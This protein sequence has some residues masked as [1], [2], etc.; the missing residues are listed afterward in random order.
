MFVGD[1][2]ARH[3]QLRGPVRSDRNGTRLLWLYNS[4]VYVQLIG[5]DEQHMCR[6]EFLAG[7]LVLICML[8]LR[9]SRVTDGLL[10]DHF[11]LLS[12]IR[13]PNNALSLRNFQRLRMNIPRQLRH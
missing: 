8:H 5:S 7:A 12:E 1:V 4:H 10:S 3:I 9:L 13:F 2:N 11:A 6:E